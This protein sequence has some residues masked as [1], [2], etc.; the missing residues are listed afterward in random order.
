MEPLVGTEKEGFTSAR[1]INVSAEKLAVLVRRPA[2]PEVAVSLRFDL[3]SIE[4]YRIEAKGEVAWADAE[5]RI[6]IKLSHM[7]EEARRRYAEWLC[8]LQRRLPERIVML[9]ACWIRLKNIGTESISLVGIFS[10]LGFEDFLR[11]RSVPANEEV[12]SITPEEIRACVH[13]GQVEAFE[14]TPKN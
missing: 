6:G 5:G 7:R 11:C 4:P 3:P 10:G 12:T 13:Q 8:R 2:K 9:A 14:D 1:L